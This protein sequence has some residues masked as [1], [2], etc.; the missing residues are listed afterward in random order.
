MLAPTFRQVDRGSSLDTFE[1]ATGM[2]ARIE[3]GKRP[4]TAGPAC[5]S[6]SLSRFTSEVF[7]DRV[8]QDLHMMWPDALLGNTNT[9]SVLNSSHFFSLRAGNGVGGQVGRGTHLEDLLELHS[10]AGVHHGYIFGCIKPPPESCHAG[11]PSLCVMG[12]HS[13]YSHWS[14]TCTPDVLHTLH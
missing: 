11:S 10:E 8:H 14:A 7:D 4:A 5:L 6:A 13:S 2:A 1:H 9:S 12:G 3:K